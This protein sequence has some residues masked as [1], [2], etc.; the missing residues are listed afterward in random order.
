MDQGEDEIQ[1]KQ[2]LLQAEIIDKNFDKTSFINFCLSKKE[3]GDDLSNWSIPELQEIIKE[4]QDSHQQEQPP[5]EVKIEEQKPS[6]N[7]KDKKEGEELNK[8]NVEK[9]EKFNADEAKNF[10]E[11]T[12]ECIKLTKQN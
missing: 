5:S 8:E 7:A 1:Q 2:Q 4:F 12:I 6:E 9:L 10:K 3:N 11:K